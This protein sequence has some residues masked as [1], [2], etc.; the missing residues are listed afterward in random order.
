VVLRDDAGKLITTPETRGHAWVK[1]AAVCLGYLNQ[2]DKTAAA[3]RNG[4]FKTGD[5]LSF[6]AE[7]W[8]YH[9]GR[10]DDQLKI[11]GQWVNPVEIEDCAISV[12]GIADAAAVGARDADGLVRMTMF[13]V[14]KGGDREALRSAVTNKLRATL[15]I[16]KCP[17]KIIF[18][19]A[20]PRTPTGK[21]QRY[22]LRKKLEQA[23]LR[24]EAADAGQSFRSS[25][26]T[27]QT[28]GARPLG[29]P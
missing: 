17:R 28:W 13:L 23:G 19:E 21:L 2:P 18:V 9:H 4:W 26:A 22:E 10:A 8:W 11:S 14:A 5:V 7:G 25:R 16:Y 3:F 24:G 1:M 15:S 27:P 12:P 29:P 20:I 6:D